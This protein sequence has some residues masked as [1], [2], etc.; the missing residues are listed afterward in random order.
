MLTD[1]E[2]IVSAFLKEEGIPNDV[3]PIDLGTAL[4]ISWY[5]VTRTKPNLMVSVTDGIIKLESFKR[6]VPIGQ[7]ELAH[8]TSLEDLAATIL[9]NVAPIPARL[10]SLAKCGSNYD[11]DMES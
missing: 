1:I 9:S 7:W 3:Y 8:P 11:K 4:P 6:R 5:L 10:S 2:F